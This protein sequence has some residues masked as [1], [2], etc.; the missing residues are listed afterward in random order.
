[1]LQAQLAWIYFAHAECV[2]TCSEWQASRR[3]CHCEQGSG[4]R[5]ARVT[6]SLRR[7]T[8][9]EIFTAA[10]EARGTAKLH[11]AARSVQVAKHPDGNMPATGDNAATLAR[12]VAQRNNAQEDD[13]TMW[14]KPKF[15]ELRLGFEVTM[16]SDYR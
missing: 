13:D 10:F 12:T 15:V 1:M 8:E 11:N 2:W 6:R 14:I 9:L 5:V 4:T 7:G 3:I 16:Y